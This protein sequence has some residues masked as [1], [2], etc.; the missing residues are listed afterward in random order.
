MDQMTVQLRQAM[1]GQMPANPGAETILDR[2]LADWMVE[3]KAIM[4]QHIPA[5]MDG[6]AQGYANIFTAQ[7]LSDILAFVS[8]PSGQRYIVGATAV[9]ADPAFANA[10]Q[11]Y[12][13]EV[14]ARLPAAQEDLRIELEA[15]FAQQQQ[16][17]PQS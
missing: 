3:S 10:N 2:W 9:I 14:L 17:P 8:T 15:Y 13:N 1:A 16:Q 5:L 4:R 7:E 11:A 12:M 6:L